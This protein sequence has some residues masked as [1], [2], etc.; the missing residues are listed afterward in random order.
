MKCYMCPREC[1]ANRESGRGFCGEGNEL[2]IAFTGLHMWEEPCIS[3]INGSGTVFFSGCSLKCVYCQNYEISAGKGHKVSVEELSDKIMQLQE[4][5]AHNLNIVT[6]G[7]FADKIPKLID[8]AKE[9]GFNL[10]V[11]YNSSGYEKVDIIKSLEGYIDVYLPDFKYASADKAELLSGARDYPEV[12][13]AC[14]REMIR[15]QPVCEYKDGLMKKGVLIRHLVLPSCL[16]ESRLVLDCIKEN[17]G[18]KTAVSLMSQYFPPRVFYGDLE[19]LNR[20]ITKR[21]QERIKDYFYAEGFTEGYIQSRTS[22]EKEYVPKW[23]I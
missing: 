5:G 22:A 13:L 3:G 4:K 16:N 18:N 14:I 19:F 11:V 9:K 17:Y 10:P 21:E 12:A 23:E 2:E 6:A 20:K 7:H 1:G 8:R 15:Q